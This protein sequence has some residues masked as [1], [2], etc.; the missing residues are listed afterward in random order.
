MGKTIEDIL[1]YIGK[2]IKDF[3][4]YDRHILIDDTNYSII[5]VFVDGLWEALLV[6]NQ[7]EKVIKELDYARN[8]MNLFDILT[9]K[10]DLPYFKDQLNVYIEKITDEDEI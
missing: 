2:S 6:D 4:I 9:E 3:H 8:M 5:I 7:T 10:M 1:G